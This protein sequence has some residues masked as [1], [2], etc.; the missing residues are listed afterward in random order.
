MR[1]F[2]LLRWRNGRLEAEIRAFGESSGAQLD[3]STVAWCESH[4][5]DLKERNKMGQSR[6]ETRDGYENQV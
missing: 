1:F 4:E 6:E 3:E 5:R 2:F